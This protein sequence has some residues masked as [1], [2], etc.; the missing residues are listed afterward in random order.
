MHLFHAYARVVT[1]RETPLDQ[2]TAFL[3]PP[4]AATTSNP[5]SIRIHRVMR[6]DV[7]CRGRWFS[8]PSHKDYQNALAASTA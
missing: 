1:V 6:L 2:L 5:P 8:R 7:T 3:H 4:L